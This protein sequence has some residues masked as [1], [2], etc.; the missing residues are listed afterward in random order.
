MKKTLTLFTLLM[1]LIIGGCR[2]KED[3][4]IEKVNEFDK[5]IS[6]LK[7]AIKK[8]V[9]VKV[10]D[11]IYIKTGGRFESYTLE[12]LSGL[13]F[14]KKRALILTMDK[15][16]ENT[17]IVINNSYILWSNYK[18]TEE[19]ATA[20]TVLNII[21]LKTVVFNIIDGIEV[22]AD[23]TINTE[24]KSLRVYFIGNSVTDTINYG[25]L[26]EIAESREHNH[27]WARH[28]IPGAPLSWLWEHPNDGFFADP[29]GNPMNAFINYTWDAISL[30]PFDRN[31]FGSG[32]DLEIIQNYVNLTKDK[33]PNLQLYI[34]QRWPRKPNDFKNTSDEWNTLWERNY[35]VVNPKWDNS[36]EGRMYFEV[37]TNEVRKVY[38]NM[39][40]ALIVPVGEVLYELN[41][42]MA[43]GE[44]AGYNSIWDIYSDGIHLRETGSF[45]V[46]ATYFATLYKEDPRGIT[47]PGVY[48]DISAEL[49]SMI[50][51]TIWDVVR[52]YKDSN[53]TT[54]AGVTEGGNVAVTA[55]KLSHSNI[56]LSISKT[57]ELTATLSPANATDKNINWTSSNETVCS[58][59]I[60]G[61]VTAKSSGTALITAASSNGRSAQCTIKV[62]AEDIAVSKISIIPATLSL[63]KGES[64]TLSAEILPVNATNKLCT[65]ESS[66]PSV[67]TVSSTGVVT[68]ISKGS[69]EITA[70]SVNGGYKSVS[71]V[72]VTIPNRAP[73]AVISANVLTGTAPLTVQFNASNSTDSDEG[74]FVLGYDWE[75]GIN[76]AVAS[77]VNPT[78]T[79][80]T[81]GTYT[82]RLRVMDSNNLR[83]E[84]VSTTVIV[85]D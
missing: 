19:F 80:T 20:P 58:V 34:Y 38:P 49:K 62:T 11:G 15:N 59:D 2:E 48:G 24:Q 18:N 55:V 4:N 69:A 43:A 77:S 64:F 14:D 39:K 85:L 78:Y 29:Y 9:T 44:I 5:M 66:S 50:L 35:D 60:N 61:K 23:G 57:V 33:S 3:N 32:D 79:Y 27:I 12:Q 41:K 47:V 68:A 45:I 26:Q 52:V 51:Q 28:M 71:S 6:E 73:N 65:W 25:G 13:S 63:S 21:E 56:E 31:V 42:K 82:V 70:T 75:F 22:Y 30:Q 10:L 53:G 16:G 72:T 8:D 67:A 54:W 37:L 74:D 17:Y 76:S 36:N 1:L 46:A 84:W 40:P 81:P 7:E 83:G